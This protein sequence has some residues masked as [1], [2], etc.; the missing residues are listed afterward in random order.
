MSPRNLVITLLE[1]LDQTDAYA[2]I[3]LTRELRNQ[4]L[5]SRDKAFVQEIFYGVIRWRL[6]LDWMIE[7][8]FQGSF[9]KCP[10]FVKNILQVSFYQL[11]FMERIPTYAVI[12]EA[13]NSGKK[14][15]GP[16]WGS[17]INAILRH[18]SRDRAGVTWP[19]KRTSPVRHL[20]VRYSHPQWLV[21][22]WISQWG[23][24]E[25]EALCQADNQIPDVTVRV[26]R[27]K[28]SP[29]QLAETLSRLDVQVTQSTYSR[30]FLRLK[31]IPDLTEL[32]SFQQGWF[33]VQDVSAGLPC[34]LIDP[35]PG[36]RIIDLCAAP[37]GKSTYM[38]E[39]AGDEAVLLAVDRN[40]ARLNLVRQTVKRLGLRSIQFAQ[41]D[42]VN[43]SSQPVDKILVDAPCSGLGVLSK[44]VD[45]RWKRTPE[46]IHELAEIQLNLLNNA[47]QFVRTGGVLVY[48]TCTIDPEENERVVEAF[49]AGHTYFEIEDASLFIGR[50]LTQPD[51]SVRTLPHRHG[52]DGSFAVRL[53]KKS[54]D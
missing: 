1:R 18:F 48:C 19:D 15:G 52:M 46:Q 51:G 20:A 42:G 50:E 23:I 45:L 41:A 36:E 13:V 29:D 2:D 54:E 24:E 7:Q 40:Y 27:L 14:R 37:G 31:H 43:F 33:T 3:L 39:L 35:K 9:S 32:P 22:R 4:A 53:V 38:A 47:A 30:D 11:A 49:L 25:T 6:R 21:A 26:N 34:I 17:K 44:R 12:N 28:S 10:P 16:Y 5:S 8:L